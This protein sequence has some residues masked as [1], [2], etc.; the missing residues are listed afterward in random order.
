M[1]IRAWCIAD[2]LA[3]IGLGSLDHF[4]FE[5]SG[6]RPVMGIFAPVNESVWEHLKMGYWGMIV[7]SVGEY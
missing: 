1:I 3:I 7:Y 2:C 4:L 6:R 5:W